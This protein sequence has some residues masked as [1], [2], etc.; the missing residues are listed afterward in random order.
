MS[1]NLKI[2]TVGVAVFTGL[3]VAYLAG[4]ETAK[5]ADLNT[6]TAQV[7]PEPE[8]PVLAQTTQPQSSGKIASVRLDLSAWEKEYTA[9][10]EA[11]E[12]EHIARHEAQNVS[13]YNP[14]FVDCTESNRVGDQDRQSPCQTTYMYPRHPY[15]SYENDALESLAYSDPLAAHILSTRY[16]VSDPGKSLDLAIHSAAISA[17]PGPLQI[18]AHRTFDVYYPKRELTI[19]DVFYHEA[20]LRVAK[21][22][23]ADSGM[24]EISLP[25]GK[26]LPE[27]PLRKLVREIEAQLVETQMTVTGSSSL[28]EL[29]DA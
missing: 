3:L 15:F 12:K 17:K 20:L 13:P 14:E 24:T 2:A 22:M 21:K 11:D 23:G 18:A 10:L 9:A 25:E 26:T 7:A 1:K 28:K 29:F 8:T 19:E 27:E 16:Q 5:T 6:A 4:Y